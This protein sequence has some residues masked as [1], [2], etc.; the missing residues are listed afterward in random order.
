MTRLMTLLKEARV[1]KELA[2]G[3]F[4]NMTIVVIL[5]LPLSGL[6]LTLAPWDSD[7]LLPSMAQRGQTFPGQ[8]CGVLLAPSTG[9]GPVWE[10]MGR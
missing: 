4:A 9:G 6:F 1:T 10:E 8:I 5:Q 7:R 2:L 3:L